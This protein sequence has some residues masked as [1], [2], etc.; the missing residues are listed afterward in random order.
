MPWPELQLALVAALALLASVAS[1]WQL[2]KLCPGPAWLQPAW[3]F[4]LGNAL[5]VVVLWDCSWLGLPA[6]KVAWPLVLGLPALNLAVEGILRLRRAPTNPPPGSGVFRD[7]RSWLFLLPIGI[8]FA[9]EAIPLLMAGVFG[10]VIYSA[11]EFHTNTGLAE[12]FATHSLRD[13]LAALPSDSSAWSAWRHITKHL[14]I[15]QHMVHALWIALS[16]QSSISTWPLMSAWIVSIQATGALLLGMYATRGRLGWALTASLLIA[17]HPLSHAACLTSFISMAMGLAF[18][19]PACALVFQTVEEGLTLRLAIP[20]G[21]CA[22][23]IFFVYQ[24]ILPVFVMVSGLFWVLSAWALRRDRRQ[25]LRICLAI[26]L[27][28]LVAAALSPAGMLWN[29]Q[30]LI[31]QSGS[32]AHGTPPSLAPEMM[33]SLVTGLAQL[34]GFWR[35][36]DSGAL[37]TSCRWLAALLLAGGLVLSFRQ[38]S[39]AR[40]L[41]AILGS[42]ALLFGFVL[43]KGG[44][45]ELMDYGLSRSI[46][47]HA[48]LFFVFGIA[49]WATLAERHKSWALAAAGSY[50]LVFFG[51]SHRYFTNVFPESDVQV[52]PAV[53]A[54]P[55]WVGRLSSDSI[56]IFDAA[57]HE[58][59]YSQVPLWRW[60]K[61]RTFFDTYLTP[62]PLKFPRN[63]AAVFD[64]PVRNFATPA[65]RDLP[66]GFEQIGS[67]GRL[68]IFKVTRP[69]VTRMDIG[70][71]V[72]EH[73]RSPVQ[74]ASNARRRDPLRRI[75][76]LCSP[77]QK[78]HSATLEFRST[79]NQA[80]QCLIAGH[81]QSLGL[82]A[83][84]PTRVSVPIDPRFYTTRFVVTS[85]APVQIRVVDFQ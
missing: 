61:P 69:F 17:A 52:L 34:P 56:L 33:A 64:T 10:T 37:S 6:G 32:G 15:G 5:W 54:Q 48:C 77:E 39:R 30:G 79:E 24:E 62:A 2:A 57:S 78:L 82:V 83:D 63:V 40:A 49:G 23:A 50:C 51:Y 8:A 55:H 68:K 72:L 66:E 41:I 60:L 27:A 19:T 36:L 14:R 11:P 70:D 85:P 81:A 58:D 71:E 80:A 7:S 13:N 43:H 76:W 31:R 4:V 75:Y 74:R 38:S 25:L 20:I 28:A 42:T 18:L 59:V 45:G 46:L 29:L 12:W 44:D 47:Y 84:S 53:V 26:V 35:Q 1:G 3:A 22:L 16:G 21:L 73:M 9:W 67:Q 65:T